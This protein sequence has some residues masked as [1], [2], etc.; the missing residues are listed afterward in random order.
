[1]NIWLNTL[2]FNPDFAAIIARMNEQTS[3]QTII[4]KVGT[5]TLT[6]GTPNLSRPNMLELIR[7][8]VHLHQSGHRV[9]LVSSGA[10]AGWT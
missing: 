7:Q 8:I 3:P 6:G 5:S 9:V 1:M 10:M 4:I 2:H